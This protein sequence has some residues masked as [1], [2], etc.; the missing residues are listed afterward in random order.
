MA[1]R[2]PGRRGAAQR[3]GAGPARGACGPGA[4]AGH[5]GYGSARL[6]YNTSFDGIRPQ[7][8]VQPARHPRRRRR[9]WPGPTGSASAWSPARAATAMPATRPTSGGVVVDLSRLRGIRRVRRSSDGGGGRPARRRAA[10]GSRAA[11]AGRRWAP[12]ARW[13]SPGSPRRRPR[14]WAWRFGLTADNLVGATIVTADGRARRVGAGTEADLYWACRGGGGGNFGI[15]TSL[16]F[17][18]RARGA[19]WFF[20]RFPWDPASEAWPA[21]QRFPPA[22]PPAL[23]RSYA[24]QRGRRVA[25]LHRAE[26]FFDSLVGAAEPGRPL[27]RVGGES[28]S[29]WN[30]V[31][32]RPRAALAW[33]PRRGYRSCHRAGPVPAA[34]C[35]ARRSTL[36]RTTSASRCRRVGAGP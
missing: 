6:V 21:W 10:P 4:A 3:R 20:I 14:L 31:D 30:S 8:V 28:V 25:R 23:R 36:S 16:T 9:W 19:A 34:R 11:P 33:L 13:A 32:D 27:T 18:H 24:R 22:A 7:A 2:A 35:R 12:L 15:V 26:Q 17:A 1:I 5:A 29:S